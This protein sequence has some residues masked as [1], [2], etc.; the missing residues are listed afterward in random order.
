MNLEQ[1]QAMTNE[2]LNELAAVKVMGFEKNEPGRIVFYKISDGKSIVAEDWNPTEDMNDAMELKTK[3]RE[4]KFDDPIR[5]NFYERLYELAN[6][7][8]HDWFLFIEPKHITIAAILAK[9]E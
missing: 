1:L 5:R 7:Q 4:L 9:G 8:E 3:I 2:D 6:S